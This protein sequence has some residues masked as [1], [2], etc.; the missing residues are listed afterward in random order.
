V[1]K[2]KS[3]TKKEKSKK[4]KK[5]VKEKSEKENALFAWIKNASAVV[6]RCLKEV[7]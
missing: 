2:E 7:C 3:C 4:E 5:R 6:C 1:R